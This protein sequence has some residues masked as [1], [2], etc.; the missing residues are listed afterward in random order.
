MLNLLGLFNVRACLSPKF[1]LDRESQILDFCRTLAP[2]EKEDLADA[3]RELT[4]ILA[5]GGIPLRKEDLF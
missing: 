5:K 1:I 3:H 2:V 4:F